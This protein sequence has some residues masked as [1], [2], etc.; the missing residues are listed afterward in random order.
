MWPGQQAASASLTI[1]PRA[2]PLCWRA[3]L[4]VL[5]DLRWEY[6]GADGVGVA[7]RVHPEPS[8]LHPRPTPYTLHP[9]PCTL[10]P[11]PQTQHPTP[12]TLHLKPNTLHPTPCTS[13]PN[14]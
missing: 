4:S 5:C 9:T 1:V 11:A 3:C 13:N 8:T 12:Y 2:L 7:W 10:H 6:R 14:P